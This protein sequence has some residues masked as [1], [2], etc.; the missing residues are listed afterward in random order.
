[1]SNV[2]ITVSLSVQT[3]LCGSLY[4]IPHWVTSSRCPMCFQRKWEAQNVENKKA[5]E[6][7]RRLGKV[8]AALRG[9]IRKKRK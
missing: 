6:E 4:A 9:I 2:D 8:N 1:M 7:I 5:E 3:C